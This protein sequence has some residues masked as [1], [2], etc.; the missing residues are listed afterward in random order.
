MNQIFVPHDLLKKKYI[1]FNVRQLLSV[2]Y[3]P[4]PPDHTFDGHSL[5][6]GSGVISLRL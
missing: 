6:V 2:S 4:N 5:T 1:F 3:T